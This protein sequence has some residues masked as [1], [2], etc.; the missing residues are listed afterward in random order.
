MVLLA[1]LGPAAL[2]GAAWLHLTTPPPV[3]KSTAAAAMDRVAAVDDWKTIITGASFGDTDIDPVALHEAMGLPGKASSF[4]IGASVAAVWY[5]VLKERVYGNGLTPDLI[6]MPISL[7]SALNPDLPGFNGKRLTDQMPEP[8]AVVL[9][10]SYGSNRAPE[11]QRVLDRRATLRDPLLNRFRRIGPS[12]F[13]GADEEDLDAAG[14]A[15]FGETHAEAGARLLPVVERDRGGEVRDRVAA[16]D[17]AESYLS[18]IV[19]LAD[20]HGTQVVIILPPV[21][22][23]AN[24]DPGLTPE[25]ERRMITW[26]N[27]R[28]VGWL[29]LRTEPYVRADFKDAV[30]MRPATATHFS[31]TVGERLV[32]MGVT[33]GAIRPAV[34]P[35]TAAAVRRIGT[36]PTL[37]EVKLAAPGD[38]CGLRV[39]V[40]A[41]AALGT[42]AADRLGAGIVSPIVVEEAGKRLNR[43]A[44]S[45]R[46]TATYLHQHRVDIGRSA[47]DAPTPE[48]RFAPEVPMEVAG[49]R[50]L[51]WV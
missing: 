29:D 51:Y 6:I 41:Y 9:R 10:R 2:T 15:V 42:R 1:L 26:A 19:D 14:R 17:P 39:D 3:V 23:G 4:C 22:P 49:D 20:E 34:V 32:A 43:G 5:A 31:K 36:P 27:S 16:A 38:V 50:S 46:C 18:D 8:D 30:H 35:V 44:A 33:G 13:F 28:K 11:L 47:P 25:L 12:W 45:R 24:A 48:L 21:S 7:A 37:P 40:G